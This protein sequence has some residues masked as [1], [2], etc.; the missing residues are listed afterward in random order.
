LILAL[1]Y[2]RANGWPGVCV[3]IRKNYFVRQY[4]N[5]GKF[6]VQGLFRESQSHDFVDKK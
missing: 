4:K 5:G 1:K 2:F 3:D 6:I